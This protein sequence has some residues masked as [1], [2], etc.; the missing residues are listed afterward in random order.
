[1]E[2]R[3]SAGCGVAQQGAAWLSG[4]R[5]GSFGA[6]GLLGQCSVRSGVRRGSVRVPRGPAQQG[7]KPGFSGVRQG[8]F[9]AEQRGSAGCGV[10]QHGAAWLSG[11][12]R[13]ASFGA[14]S[15]LGQCSVHSRVQCVLAQLVV[16]R[17]AI[18]YEIEPERGR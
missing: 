12:R 3:G 6:G 16:R 17:A 9:G 1:M 15:F 7:A 2:R 13:S 18:R 5:R 10:A 14:G 8:S 11:V 4:V